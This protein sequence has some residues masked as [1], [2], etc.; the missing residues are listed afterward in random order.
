MLLL[1][2]QTCSMMEYLPGCFKEVAT[3]TG[4]VMEMYGR[5][6]VHAT[7]WTLHPE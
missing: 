4:A 6:N 5:D 1:G 3:N 7:L 2:R